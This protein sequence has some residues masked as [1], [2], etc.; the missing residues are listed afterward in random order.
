M[1]YAVALRLV[2]LAILAMGGGLA[3][4][5]YL[6]FRRNKNRGFL[7]TAVGLALIAGSFLPI[8]LL[9][10]LV[11][12]ELTQVNLSVAVAQM[13]GLSLLLYGVLHQR[14]A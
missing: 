10:E 8:G 14:D 5:A 6:A 1:D 7:F 3:Y 4:M 9:L 13:A 11:G 12:L 2:H